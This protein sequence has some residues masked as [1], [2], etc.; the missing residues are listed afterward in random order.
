MS[1]LMDILNENEGKVDLMA[2]PAKQV[3]FNDE[4]ERF[5]F[6]FYESGTYVIVNVA[7]KFLW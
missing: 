1:A 5:N 2:Q 7:I 4:Q 3:F 6:Y